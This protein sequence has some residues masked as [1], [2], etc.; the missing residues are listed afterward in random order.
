M[1]NAIRLVNGGAIQVRT[2]VLAGVGPQGPRGPAGPPGPDGPQGPVG[3]TGPMGQILNVQ[4]MSSVSGNVAIAANTDALVA[5]GTVRYDDIGAATSSTTYTLANAGDYFCSVWL[6]FDNIASKDLWVISSLAGT[7]V[8][9]TFAGGFATFAYPVRANAGET[10]RVYARSATAQNVTQG[11]ITIS[12]IGSGAQGPVG[13]AGPQGPVGPTGPQGPA[14]P[15]GSA[16]AGY[17][18]YDALNGA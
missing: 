18:T 1:S 6:G 10:L 7:V 2:G 5:F 4:T 15:T 14:G 3:E 16:G 12:R 17:T 11:A 9:G 13:P 8:R